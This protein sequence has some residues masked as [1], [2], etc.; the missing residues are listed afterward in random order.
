MARRSPTGPTSRAHSTDAPRDAAAEKA[1]TERSWS[2][3]L[4]VLLASG[5]GLAAAHAHGLVHRDFKPDNVMIGADGRVRVMDFG[6]VRAAVSLS[7]ESVEET[8]SGAHMSAAMARAA[9]ED[10]PHMHASLDGGSAFTS[11][12]TMAGALLGTP[13]YMAP[14][15]L[16]GEEADAR[17][18]QFSYCVVLWQCLYGDR[19]FAGDTPLA[20]LFA[21]SHAQFRETPNTRGVPTWI[22]R[23][24]ERGLSAEPASRWPD[25]PSL[26]RALTDDP[27]VRRRPYVFGG[28]ALAAVGAVTAAVIVLQPDPP[29]PPCEHAGEEIQ[30]LWS[31]A[32]KSELEATFTGSKLIYADESWAR[33]AAELDDWSTRWVSARRDAC[34]ATEVRREQSPELLDLRMACLDQQLQRFGALVDVLADADATVIEK[35]IEAVEALPTLEV[36][37]D[38]SWLTAAVRPPEDTELA[39]SVER[40]RQNI[41]RAEALTDGGKP[42]DA[43]PIAEQAEAR[44]RDLGWQPLLAEA[45]TTLAR[46]QQERGEFAK[47]RAAFEAAYFAARRGGHDEVTLRAISLL[48]YTLGVGLGE[49]DT[50]SAWIQHALAEADRVG[51][52]DLTGEV[53]T[54]IGIHHYVRGEMREAAA[55]FEHALELHTDAKSTGLASAHLN[56]GTIL[57]YIDPARRKQAFEELDLGLTM[58][59]EIVGEQ[60]P[61]VANALSNYATV[62]GM[63]DEH[64]AAIELLERALVIDVK[65][66]GESH[67]MT[68]LVELN[69]ATNLSRLDSPESAQR[70]LELAERSLV[71]HRQVFGDQHTRVAESER[72]VGRALLDLDR[73]VDARPHFDTALAIW[74]STFDEGHGQVVATKQLIARC[75]SLTQREDEAIDTLASLLEY[76]LEVGVRAGI[77]LDLANLLAKRD[78]ERAQQLLDA[79]LP[80]VNEHGTEG[81]RRLV[82]GVREQLRTAQMTK[83]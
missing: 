83:P 35:A 36:C 17:A 66:L 56:Y 45:A 13:A 55:A 22:R 75:N 79:S 12:L 52:P 25:M 42:N 50:A 3:V 23:A 30:Q 5:R 71:T 67:P 9:L 18:D 16:R 10:L 38:R 57:I 29:P 74:R 64:E 33:V 68:A 62:H 65:A 37:A 24:L 19:P 31:D 76:E 61:I 1:A 4:E 14:E 6:L 59:L 58:M 70:G 40:V 60:H 46:V 21:I 77:E 47:S 15:Q 28:L 81:E 39:A 69:L 44:A 78:P 54:S 41:A 73:P 51:R 72:A 8:G 43:L 53:Y 2:D 49:F 11:H 80:Y 7:S 82:D 32:R 34:E 63:L 26:L 48:I 27:K 20:V